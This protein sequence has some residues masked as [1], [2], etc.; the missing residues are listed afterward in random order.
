M[1]ASGVGGSAWRRR[2]GYG[3]GA[4]LAGLVAVALA[5]CGSSGSNFSCSSI[6]ACV[7]LEGYFEPL[8]V[9]YTAEKLIAHAKPSL[10]LTG[11]KCSPSN[12][13]PTPTCVFESDGQPTIKLVASVARDGRSFTA[14]VTGVPGLDSITASAGDCDPNGSGTPC[15]MPP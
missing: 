1:I 5:G 3:V 11:F 8:T 2:R 4:I 9:G 13:E 15:T 6:P 10:N 14:S 12:S 7:N